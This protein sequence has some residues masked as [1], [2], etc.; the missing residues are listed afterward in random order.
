MIKSKFHILPVVAAALALTMGAPATAAGYYDGKTVTVIIGAGAGGGLTRSGRA[1]MQG[2]QKQLGN[3]AT[4]IIVKNMTGGAGAKALNFLAEKA[5]PDGLTLAFGPPNQ[6]AKLI[7]LPGIRFE[8]AEFQVVGAQDTSFVSIVSSTA[9]TGIKQAGDMIKAGSLVVGGR[10]PNSSLDI[11]ARMPLHILGVKYRYV[12]G[13]RNQPKLKSALMQNEVNYVTTGHTGHVAFYE[14]D[15]LKKGTAV[16]VYY[17]SA[18]DKNGNHLKL[19][20]RY[21]SNIKHFVDYY[22]DAHGGKLPSGPLWEAYKWFST[23]NTR[24]QILFAPKDV[25]AERVEELRAAYAK[26]IKDP[27]FLKDYKKQFKVIPNYLV[28][29][30]AEWLTKGY[31]NISAEAVKGM[32]QLVNVKAGKKKKK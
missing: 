25:P 18:L 6:F 32:K 19:T 10:G 28:G 21:P 1:V 14:N 17:H 26:M 12:P 4:K 15:L 7:G 16:A 8:P 24:S 29:K 5:R 22:K 2:M 13:Y 30:D 3:D 9:G 27:Q 20:E 23:Y 11:F 31:R